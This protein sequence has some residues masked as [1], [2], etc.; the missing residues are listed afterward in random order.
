MYVFFSLSSDGI[1]KEFHKIKLHEI[2]IRGGWHNQ[3][4]DIK[5]WKS[6]NV[7]RCVINLN[8]TNNKQALK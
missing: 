6:L 7:H 1:I 3:P 4:S 2:F 5:T 8:D